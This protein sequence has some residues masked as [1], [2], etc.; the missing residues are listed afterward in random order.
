MSAGSLKDNSGVLAPRTQHYLAVEKPGSNSKTASRQIQSPWWMGGTGEASDCRVGQGRSRSGDGGGYARGGRGSWDSGAARHPCS[1]GGM[2]QS[3]AVGRA[4]H[5]GHPIAAAMPGGGLRIAATSRW[6]WR[7]FWPGI[8][9]W[10]IAS[11]FPAFPIETVAGLM[12]AATPTAS[13]RV[14]LRVCTT[15]V[16]V[17]PPNG[18]SGP[19][20]DSWTGEAGKCLRCAG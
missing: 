1:R 10:L 4:I 5:S 18:N 8:T 16:F 12:V 13:S 17:R 9:M 7:T 3:D 6:T 14:R 20:V 15:D 19:C 11:G 2:G